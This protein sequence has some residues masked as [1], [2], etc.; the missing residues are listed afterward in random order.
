MIWLLVV[1]LGLALG[2]FFNVCIHRIPLGQS[3][4]FPPSYC[5]RCKKRIRP[6]DN[7]PVLSWILLGGRCRSCRKPISLR[8]PVVEA[9]T[10]L[11]FAAIFARFGLSWETLSGLVFVS[12]LLV[13]AFVDLDHQVIPFRLSIPGVI[14]GITL[15]FL[16]PGRTVDALLGA[17]AGAGFVL[18]AWLL[19]R[20]V[21][22][23]VFRRFGID[24]KEGIGVGDLPF[25]AM[26]GSFL[27]LSSTLVAL[28][29]AVAV[30]VAIGLVLQW[31]GRTGKG[32]P[33]PFGPFLAAGALVGL[34]FG[35]S[36]ADWYVAAVLS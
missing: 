29:A 7:I 17:A 4:V 9:G 15:S 20:Y 13:M 33:I 1:L 10:A 2:S 35:A 8:Y 18:F 31:V 30:G 32:Q 16:P 11:L 6:Y 12:L 24:Q 34:F 5:P 25:A 22:A 23:G 3:V 26:L 21:L 36:I 19:W 27:G 14:L 28:F